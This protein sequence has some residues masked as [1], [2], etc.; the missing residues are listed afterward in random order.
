MTEGFKQSIEYLYRGIPSLSLSL[1]DTP[2]QYLRIR[3]DVLDIADYDL[4]VGS[5]DELLHQRQDVRLNIRMNVCQ[6]SIDQLTERMPAMATIAKKHWPRV[7]KTLLEHEMSAQA[8]SNPNGPAQEAE[9][10]L[11]HLSDEDSEFEDHNNDDDRDY[12]RLKSLIFIEISNGRLHES[13]RVSL[14]VLPRTTLENESYGGFRLV[15]ANARGEKAYDQTY[16]LARC[17]ILPNV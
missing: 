4:L 16:D 15:L 1:T 12:A 17:D 13:L 11:W 7:M 10:L 9:E 5:F 14:K 8:L 3:R 6:I 2:I